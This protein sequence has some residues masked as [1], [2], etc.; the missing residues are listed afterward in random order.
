MDYTTSYGSWALVLGGSEGLGRAIACELALRGMNVALAARRAQP[1]RDAAAKITSDYGVQTKIIQIDLSS[2]D[3]VS[4]IEAGMGGED[5]SFLVY[6]AAAEPYG[7]F[8]DLDLDEHLVNVAVN[9]T[10][11]TRIVHHFGRKM[12]E[13]GNGGVVLC[14]SL[15]G[16]QGLFSWVSYGAAKSYETILGEGLWYEL[17]QHGVG[18]CTLMVGTTWTE[19]LQRT[20]K[21]L[22]GIFANGREPANL[23]PGMPIPQ[24]P[25]DAAA[26][27][28]AQLDKE[29]LPLIFANPEDEE[30]SKMMASI[31]RAD[32]IRM[33]AEA[34][35][36]WYSSAIG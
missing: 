34:Q 11:P 19:S 27:L 33:A 6:N 23:P 9:I 36:N 22:K 32:L 30:R 7:E 20:Q 3:V 24:L 31:P 28:F 10:A 4:Q 26:N 14:S 17:G 1:L 21:K 35:R 15:A 18:A 13:K 8:L 2:E 29:W 12:V 5:V 16:A 25:E